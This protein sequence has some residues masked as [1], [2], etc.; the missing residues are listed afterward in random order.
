MIT[1]TEVSDINKIAA[2]LSGLM[3]NG[4]HEGIWH[5]LVNALPAA[6]Y[7]TDPRGRIIFY[8]D[9]A[10]TCGGAARTGQN[11]FAVRGSCTD[12]TAFRCLTMNALWRLH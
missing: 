1:R 3:S 10:A 9:A 8:N 12:P 6:I 4:Q 7:I 11:E 2:T 5:E